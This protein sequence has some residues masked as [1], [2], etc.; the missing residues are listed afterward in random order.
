M[1]IVR[2]PIDEACH[3]RDA[4]ECACAYTSAWAHSVCFCRALGSKLTPTSGTR[5][6]HKPFSSSLQSMSSECST[7]NT[8]ETS[9]PPR[10]HLVGGK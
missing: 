2:H 10:Q 9:V 7:R 4:R 6:T 8:D 1:W 5:R 3:L